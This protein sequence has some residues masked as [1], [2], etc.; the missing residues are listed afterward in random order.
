MLS[1]EVLTV[2]RYGQRGAFGD[3]ESDLLT[4][5]LNYLNRLQLTA[6]VASKYYNL[7]LC[8]TES[9]PGHFL[10]FSSPFLA[11]YVLLFHLRD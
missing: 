7:F 3:E 5:K 1:P 6:P 2:K 9:I 4:A 11:L 10:L 8:L